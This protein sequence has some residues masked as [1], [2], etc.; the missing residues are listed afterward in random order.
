IPNHEP[1]SSIDSFWLAAGHISHCLLYVDKG[2]SVEQLRDV[3]STRLLSKPELG[4]FRSRL[5]HRGLCRSPYWRYDPEFGTVEEHVIE[6]DPVDS[7]RALRHRLT[8]LMS[9][10]LPMEKPLWQ[11]R[12]AAATHCDQ[13]VLIVRVHQ[14]LSQSGLV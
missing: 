3:I 13:V 2:L 7:N 1:L 8:S 12:Y 11:I 14:T 9:Q 4:R 5:V 6:D 10:P